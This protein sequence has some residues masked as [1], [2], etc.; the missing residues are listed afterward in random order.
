MLTKSYTIEIKIK[1]DNRETN[2]KLITNSE[3]YYTF[4]PNET[5]DFYNK[6]T[7]QSYIIKGS[8]Y[9]ILTSK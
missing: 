2:T 3:S 9:I 8:A 1:L 5:N 7:M 4:T 6:K